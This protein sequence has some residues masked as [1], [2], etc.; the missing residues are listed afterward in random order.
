MCV[1]YGHVNVYEEPTGMEWNGMMCCGMVW[2]WLA[3]ACTRR[4]GIEGV[5]DH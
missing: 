3:F 2:C 1:L 4:T 5:G